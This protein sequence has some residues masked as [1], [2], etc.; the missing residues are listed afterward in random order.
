MKGGAYFTIVI[1]QLDAA[2]PVWECSQD[3]ALAGSRIFKS[4]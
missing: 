4:G 1:K 2:L 3:S